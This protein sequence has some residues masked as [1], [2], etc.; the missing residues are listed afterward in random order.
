MKISAILQKMSFLQFV[1]KRDWIDGGPHPMFRVS[2]ALYEVLLSEIMRGAASAL[3]NKEAGGQ[4]HALGR[5][6]MAKFAGGLVKGWDDGDDI[7]PPW[8]GPHPHWQWDFAQMVPDTAPAVSG[9]ML[10]RLAQPSVAVDEMP[11]A[12]RDLLLANVIRTAA[13]L[14]SDQGYSERLKGIGEQLVGGVAGSKSKA[15][16]EYCAT[17]VKPRHARIVRG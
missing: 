10:S 13:C 7:C 1:D 17:P 8:F 2:S 9:D 15:F 12:F 16:D 6:M 3:E 4:L 5:E 14:T 11:G